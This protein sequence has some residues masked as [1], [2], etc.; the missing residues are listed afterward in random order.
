M[1]VLQSRMQIPEIFAIQA[2]RRP[3]KT[4]VRCGQ[5]Q[6]SYGALESRAT[7]LAKQLRDA[8]VKNGDRVAVCLDRSIDLVVSILAVLR[9]GAAYV[10]LDPSYPARRINRNVADAR[11][12]TVITQEDLYHVFAR[13]SVAIFSPSGRPVSGN[14]VRM[15]VWPF[16]GDLE[17]LAYIMYTSGST[18]DPKGVR[19]SHRN[20]VCL[21]AAV[22]QQMAW[23]TEDVWTQFHSAAF[24]FSVWEIW[25]ALLNGGTLIVVPYA[26]SR[27]PQSFC[28]LL[29]A[30]R[31]TIL[32]QTPT[33]FR[34]LLSNSNILNDRE[35]ALRYV[36]FGGEMLTPSDLRPWFAHH[37]RIN[38]VMVNMYGTTEATVHSTFKSI[39]GAD[40]LNGNKSVIG[41]PLAGTSIYLLDDSLNEVS[42]GSVG[43]IYIGGDG[44]SLGYCN[45]A[46]TARRFLTD[47]SRPSAR[48]YRTGDLARR[49]SGGELE[50]IGRI[51]QQVKIR[52]HRVEPAEVVR[53]LLEHPNV[54]QATVLAGDDPYGMRSLEA[55]LV[56]TPTKP[57]LQEMRKYL[58]QRLPEYM[59]PTKMSS[60]TEYPMTASGK[61][62]VARLKQLA[63]PLTVMQQREATRDLERLV[64]SVWAS[65]L[66]VSDIDPDSSFFDLGGTS[67]NLVQV[68]ARLKLIADKVRLIDL[69]KYPSVASLAQYLS[70][71]AGHT[72][73]NG[74]DRPHDH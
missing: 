51:D 3:R 2:S 57:S 61:L 30:E 6:I 27:D 56:C 29:H 16:D 26:I 60:V 59:V 21:F 15:R 43:E 39:S 50:Y 55:Y 67:L 28:D 42:D 35:L 31:V 8:G 58:L 33:A 13:I 23:S 22:A 20:V 25:G 14:K 7:L 49:T 66:G 62:D 17:N 47:I 68:H 71:V 70:T 45:V 32:S 12:N 64:G 36:V 18:G 72:E 48:M 65:V 4:A 53:G 44:V 69:Y 46:Q 37:N 1:D 52:G 63:S 11:V 40:T 34:N 9:A 19:I 5:D 54:Q 74:D 41:F 38:P 24:D 10:P 73:G